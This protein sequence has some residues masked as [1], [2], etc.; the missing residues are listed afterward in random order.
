[1]L[2]GGSIISVGVATA[3]H[4]TLYLLDRM[5]HFGRSVCLGWSD[6]VFWTVVVFFFPSFLFAVYRIQWRIQPTQIPIS[7]G[8][9]HTVSPLFVNQSCFFWS[10]QFSII[11]GNNIN[12]M[13]VIWAWITQV[14]W[15]MFLFIYST[16]MR[17]AFATNFTTKQHTHKK[18]TNTFWGNLASLQSN[19]IHF[20]RTTLTIIWLISYICF[21]LLLVFFSSLI[22]LRFIMSTFAIYLHQCGVRSWAFFLW[23]IQWMICY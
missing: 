23:K 3:I 19:D 22:W 16:G 9:H 18:K 4:I 5:N 12:C 11:H 20:E 14:I 13:Y 7:I 8:A 2:I 15:I 1:M 6:D 21:C 17:R 10:R